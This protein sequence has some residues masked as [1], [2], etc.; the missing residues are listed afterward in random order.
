M[1]RRNATVLSV[2]AGEKFTARGEAYTINPSEPADYTRLLEHLLERKQVPRQIAYLWGME[3]GDQAEDRCFHQLVTLLQTLGAKVPDQAV[4]ITAVS[5]RSVSLQREPVQHPHGRAAQ[6]TVPGCP[7][8]ISDAALPAGRRRRDGIRAAGR[9][10]PR[11]G[12]KR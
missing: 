7:A 4:T 3:P 12:R 2:T 5:R 9:A 8:G 6:R 10:P 1:R 11:R